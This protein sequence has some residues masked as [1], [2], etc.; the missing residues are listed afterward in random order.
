MNSSFEAIVRFFNEAEGGRRMP[1]CKRYCPQ[2]KLADVF[3]SCE[4]VIETSEET[5]NFNQDYMASVSLRFPEQYGHL[6]M[7]NMELCFFEGSKK[8]GTGRIISP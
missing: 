5:L 1:P 6:I 3:T 8:T 4:I 7:P 2:L